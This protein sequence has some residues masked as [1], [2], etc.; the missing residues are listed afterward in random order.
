M[1]ENPLKP[2]AQ[3]VVNILSVR[4]DHLGKMK[5]MATADGYVM[6]RRPYCKPFVVTLEYWM[7]LSEKPYEYINVEKQ[8]S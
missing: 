2:I 4:Y 8:G 3:E 5:L 7:K 1:S 6:A